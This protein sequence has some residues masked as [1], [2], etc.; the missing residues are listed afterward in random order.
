MG[1]IVATYD[2]MPES[3][4]VNLENVVKS[5]SGIIPA[6]VKMLETKIEPV[7]FGLKKVNAGFVIDDSDDSI[8]DK[9]EQALRSI[10]GI[11]NV[12]CVSNT[13]L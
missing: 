1:Q 11:E 2:L 7:A 6:G 10:A 4:E 3:T 9:L 13:V 12:E 5:I 8:G